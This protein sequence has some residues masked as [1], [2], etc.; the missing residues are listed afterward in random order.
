MKNWILIGLAG[1]TGWYLLRKGQ[2]AY[3]TKLLF[4]KLGFANK[5]FQLVFSIQNPTNDNAKVSAI[6]GEVYLGDKLIADFSSFSEQNIAPRSE[7]E[8]KVQAS[9]TIGILQLIS[10]KGWLK[11][12]LAYTI[13][14]TANFDGIV[15]P[16]N[17][18]ASLI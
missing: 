1:L 18:K 10:T 17:Y 13:K 7:S 5:K 2:L 14:G 15:L 11:K 6:T 8:F 16:F 9:P 3:R 4:K 12:G